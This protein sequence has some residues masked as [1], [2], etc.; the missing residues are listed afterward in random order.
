M[1]DLAVKL[2]NLEYWG[3]RFG[4]NEWSPKAKQEARRYLIQDWAGPRR[5][6]RQDFAKALLS[7][8][9][10]GSLRRI[11]L[12]FLYDLE[13]STHIDHLTA[14]PDMVSPSINDLFST[15]L[16]HLAHHLQRLHLRVVADETLFQPK[17]NCTLSWPNL[18]SLVVVFHMVS[19]SGQW[20]FIGP[21]GEGRN[22][23]AFKV[24][25][26]SYPP[27]ETTPYDEDMI[28]QIDHDGDRRLYIGS[29]TS[30]FR[31]VPNDTTL[32]PFLM[33]FAKAASNMRALQ[34]AALWCPVS[35]VP[36]D[37]NGDDSRPEMFSKDCPDTKRVAWGVHYQARGELDDTW[38]G[39][40]FPTEVPLL[41][42][43]VGLWRP[44]PE[45][46][47][48]FQQIGGT[49]WNDSLKEHWEDEYSGK[50]LVDRSRFE[51]FMQ[52]EVDMVGLIPSPR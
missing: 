29:Q 19:P 3:C 39:G 28:D 2:P 44:D 48:L 33:A 18:E 9:L 21:N 40:N 26:A 35:W 24:D 4:G 49:S 41:W 7:A 27:L 14:Q 16:H 17:D 25:D 46:H 51:Y 34:E 32:R 12:D 20:C 45:L 37:E 43:K 15:S 8:R 5:D 36:N 52:E 30:R 23:A 47:E 1:V 31:I 13:R 42:W 22:T 6:T 38:Q 10:P 11:R 50:G